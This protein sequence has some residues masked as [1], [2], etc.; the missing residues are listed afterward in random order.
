MTHDTVYLPEQLNTRITKGRSVAWK[1]SASMIFFLPL[2]WGSQRAVRFPLASV[3]PGLGRVAQRRG[4]SQEV[5]KT[6]NE[7]LEGLRLCFQE[8]SSHHIQAGNFAD[9]AILLPGAFQ[10]MRHYLDKL[11]VD[12][13]VLQLAWKYNF[14]SN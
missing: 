7:G 2:A 10:E 12:I 13:G 4:G 3:P 1:S 6:P 11:A 14:V 9:A 8:S 5:H